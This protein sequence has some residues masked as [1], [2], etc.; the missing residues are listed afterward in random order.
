MFEDLDV[1]FQHFG[2][3]AGPVSAILFGVGL[4]VAGLSSS[5]VG[6]LSGD[7]IMQGFISITE[8]R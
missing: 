8:S 2:T 4:L 6:T 5:S 1:A 3:L 7:I